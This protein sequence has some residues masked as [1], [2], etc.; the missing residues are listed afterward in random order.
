M[1][2]S[3]RTA[4]G[5]TPGVVHG[6]VIIIA[7]SVVGVF[8]RGQTRSQKRCS[9]LWL[10]WLIS[11]VSGVLTTTRLEGHIAL[12]AAAALGSALAAYMCERTQS[13]SARVKLFVSIPF[14]IHTAVQVLLGAMD[15]WLSIIP[16]GVSV[17][18]W[19]WGI[20]HA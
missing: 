12:A 5:V 18:A 20:L 10:A 15:G 7:A 19:G 1:T 3:T 6:A 17:V 16:A 13:L 9:Q 11:L 14:V 8:A 2:A 4:G